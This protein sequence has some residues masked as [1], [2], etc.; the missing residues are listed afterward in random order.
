MVGELIRA[1][2]KKAGMSQ[3]VL[4]DKVNLTQGEIAHYEN[5]RRE[6]PCSK[7]FEIAEALG[8]T[9]IEIIE[10]EHHSIKD[11]EIVVWKDHQHAP[12]IKKSIVV[13]ES[14]SHWAA[15]LVANIESFYTGLMSE[16]NIETTIKNTVDKAIDDKMFERT[17]YQKTNPFAKIGGHGERPPKK[18]RPK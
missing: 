12:L 6:I 18:S 16:R 9:I 7:M 2:R 14:K 13:L 3:E 17:G 11:A 10:P 8:M 1:A 5:N 15:S 4:A